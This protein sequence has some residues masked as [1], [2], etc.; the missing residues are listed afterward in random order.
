ME[1]ALRALMVGS[2]A[3]VVSVVVNQV[4]RLLEWRVA[5]DGVAQQLAK[6]GVF[7]PTHP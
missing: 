3:R 1:D 6:R 4:Q 2:A 5:L 7:E